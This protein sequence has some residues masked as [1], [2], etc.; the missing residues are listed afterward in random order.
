MANR[1]D[2]NEVK[3]IL[4]TDLTDAAIEAF[5]TAANL[6]VTKYLEDEDLSDAQLKE[7]ERWY[8]AHLIACT[9]QREVQKENVGQASVTYG[10][11][12]DLG[13]DATMYGQQVKLLDTSGILS[14][15]EKNVGLKA[16]VVHAV[17]SFDDDEEGIDG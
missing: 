6:T 2:P 4:D 16:V 10:G 15:I 7:I 8:T 1:V 5:I 9:R 3:E 14:N 11:R 13:L 17:T 12:T